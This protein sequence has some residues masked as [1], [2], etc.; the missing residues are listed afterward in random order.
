MGEPPLIRYIRDPSSLDVKDL[1]WMLGEVERLR[2]E[3]WSALCAAAVTARGT[4]PSSDVG[5]L[6]V[7]EVANKLKF[8]RGHVYELVRQGR[9]RV[10][11]SGR[12]VRVPIDA[13]HDLHTI[14]V[15]KG[16]NLEDTATLSSR[17][18]GRG[19]RTPPTHVDTEARASTTSPSSP[20]G[21]RRKGAET[22]RST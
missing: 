4:A 18:R 1:P 13:L 21:R 8:S 7:T 20:S 16:I 6:T 11:R 3:L 14:G 5:F 10:I 17:R 2:A 15:A 22:R 19:G 9:L 12:S